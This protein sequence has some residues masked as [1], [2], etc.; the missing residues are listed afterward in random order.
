MFS[1]G[2]RGLDVQMESKPVK[3]LGAGLSGLTCA[4]NLAKA[5]YKVDVYER[6]PLVGGHYKQN[7]QML[8][9]WFSKEDVIEELEKC[10]IKINWINKI[11]QIEIYLKDQKVV[12]Y[13][14][15]SPIGYTVLRGGEDSFEADLAKQAVSQGV[16]IITNFEK[17]IKVDVVATGVSKILTVGYGQVYQ[18]KFDPA[19]LK[20]LFNPDYSPTVGY[21]YFFPH[22]REVATVKTSKTLK[23]EG[24]D[25][26]KNLEEFKKQYLG[27]KI[28]RENFL[29][30]F[31][32][33]RS[34]G[35]PKS[36]ISSQGTFLVG[37]TAGFQDE[38]FR[39]GMRY[40]IISGYLAAKAIIQDLDYDELWKKRF[41]S[42]F[43]RTARV[44]KIFC[45][46]KKKGLKSLPE[47]LE[48]YIEIDRF[49]KLWL[50]GGFNG[51]LALSPLYQH[52]LF[53]KFFLEVALKVLSSFNLFS[54]KD[55]IDL[56]PL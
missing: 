35:I 48:L 13:G 54:K 8:P 38:L 23:D 56:P 50:S 16:R 28:R 5:G 17:D 51:L 26:K 31:G 27:E 46:F 18:G 37:E 47:S 45:D 2:Q 34:F 40:A 32:T 11:E 43:Q 3:I 20:V 36:A 15:K 10:N 4:L 22:S 53:N 39:F 44:R 49:K 14:K 7:P 9:N 52:F 33:K 6:C 41:L 19:T 25:V 12:F 42:E 29:Y 21:C 30:D 1:P 55:E 24:V